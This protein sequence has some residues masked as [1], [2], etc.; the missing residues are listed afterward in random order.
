MMISRSMAVTSLLGGISTNHFVY[1]GS[2]LPRPSTSK[3]L[4]NA[5]QERDFLT[6]FTFR[7]CKKYCVRLEILKEIENLEDRLKNWANCKAFARAAMAAWR[8]FGINDARTIAV[9]D[10]CSGRA[11]RTKSTKVTWPTSSACT[12]VNKTS[13]FCRGCSLA[14]TVRFDTRS[15]GFRNKSRLVGHRIGYCE[16]TSTNLTM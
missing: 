12:N 16:K 5:C 13:A 14:A 11:S 4:R 1:D 2:R 9:L 8:Q 10:Y 6:A 7:S 3:N 15:R